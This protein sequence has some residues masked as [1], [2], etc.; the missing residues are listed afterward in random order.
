MD[1]SFESALT[2]E[3]FWLRLRLHWSKEPLIMETS[4][5]GWF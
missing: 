5:R 1:I 3:K 2:R 4:L